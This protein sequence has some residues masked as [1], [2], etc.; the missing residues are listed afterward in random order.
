[1]ITQNNHKERTIFDLFTEYLVK[2]STNN[3]VNDF[4][5]PLTNKFGAT[6]LDKMYKT[7]NTATDTLKTDTFVAILE[8]MDADFRNSATRMSYLYVNKMT[9]RTVLTPL[10]YI[11]YNRTIYRYKDDKT[12]Y[13]CH[14]DEKLGLDKY[15]RISKEVLAIIVKEYADSNSMIKTGKHVA[16]I[17]NGYGSNPLS[18]QTVYNSI[19]KVGVLESKHKMQE[20]TPDTIYIMA[21]EKYVAS[22]NK[23]GSVDKSNPKTMV[24][25]AIIFEGSAALT[26]K[27]GLPLNRN[28]LINP[29]VVSSTCNASKFESNLLDAIYQ[30]YDISKIKQIHIL[31]DGAHWIKN[32]TRTIKLDGAT[33]TF[34]LDRFHYKQALNKLTKDK[35]I[36]SILSNYV[37]TG[38]IKSFKE[39]VSSLLEG[40][41]ISKVQENSIKYIT[42]NCK[43]IYNAYNV[44]DEGCPMEQAI[45]HIFAAVFTSVP[46]AYY[47]HNLEVYVQNRAHFYNKED[48]VSMVLNK[49]NKDDDDNVYHR[50]GTRFDQLYDNRKDEPYKV[51]FNTQFQ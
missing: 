34:S 48:I 1:M 7:I 11:T 4:M 40:K 22:Q 17:I 18:R 49:F 44:V 25:A 50:E 24:K 2:E 3:L 28:I 20:A 35:D 6:N 29:Y 41:E 32:L 37:V 30:R 5:S 19:K 38:D 33:T 42:N 8:K 27:K 46:K 15:E 26:G 31:G 10:G 16:N 12:K 43:Y 21:D 23:I 47:K 39:I 14:V 13:C 36:L 9:S 45:S 51:N